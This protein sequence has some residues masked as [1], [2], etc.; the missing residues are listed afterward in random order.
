MQKKITLMVGNCKRCGKELLTARRSVYG[1]DK[2][3]EEFGV[4]CSSC[5]TQEESASLIHS[6]GKTIQTKSFNKAFL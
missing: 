6:I 4:V 5:A 1:L 2:E 3:K